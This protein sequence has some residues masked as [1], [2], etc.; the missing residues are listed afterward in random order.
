MINHRRSLILFSIFAA[1]VICSLLVSHPQTGL[2]QSPEQRNL[3]LDNPAVAF[4]KMDPLLHIR[5]SKIA[6]NGEMLFSVG[7]E[8]GGYVIRFYLPRYGRFVFSTRPHPKYE[9]E[10]V[11][12]IDNRKISFR[13]EGKQFEWIVEAPLVE[14]GTIS[15][16]WMMHDRHPEPLKDKPYG[17]GEVGASTHYEALLPSN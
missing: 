9:F 13:S 12:V 10:Q 3:N 6:V 8:T 2:A 15:T 1:V 5:D 4:S 17:S 16:L 7:G 14:N 11:E